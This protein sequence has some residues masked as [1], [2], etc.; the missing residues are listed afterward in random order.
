LNAIVDHLVYATSDLHQGMRDIE[1]LLGVSPVLGGQHHGRG[2]HNALI[3]LGDDAYLEIVAPDPDQAQSQPRWLGVDSAARG[4]ISTWAVKRSHLVDFRTAALE[5]GV[6][7]G[8]VHSASRRRADGVELSWRLTEPDPLVADGV[9]PF[10]IDWGGSPHPS[11][12]A[13]QGA[14]LVDLRLEHPDAPMVERMLRALEL[15][16][17]VTAANVAAVIATIEGRSGRV[18]LR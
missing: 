9:I 15:D 17:C 3:A 4:H 16:V 12:A 1:A 5:S 13:P 2:T 10:F 11:A 6:P 8:D 7:L 14:T 18:E